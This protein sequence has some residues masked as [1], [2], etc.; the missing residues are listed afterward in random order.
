MSQTSNAFDQIT[1]I[2]FQTRSGDQIVV[3]AEGLKVDP[4]RVLLISEADY[5]LA[6][7]LGRSGSS[8]TQAMPILSSAMPSIKLKMPSPGNWRIVYETDHAVSMT[9]DVSP[10]I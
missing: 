2:A 7:R 5:Q 9:V 4:L 8:R 3:S 10:D 6:M 1:S